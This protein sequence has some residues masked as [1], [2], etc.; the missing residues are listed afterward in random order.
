MVGGIPLEAA[1]V[2][3]ILELFGGLLGGP[4]APEAERPSGIVGAEEEE[5]CG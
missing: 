5:A 3:R 1:S 2:C 4:E